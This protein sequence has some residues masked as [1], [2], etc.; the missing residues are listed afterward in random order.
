[1]AAE[2]PE[3]DIANHILQAL[4]RGSYERLRG[5]LEPVPLPAKAVIYRADETIDQVFFVESGFVSMVKSMSDGRTVE[6]G[7][8][9]KEGLVGLS[10]LHGMDRSIF[11]CIVQIPGL[12]FRVASAPL[13]REMRHDTALREVTLRYSYVTVDQ[14]A[15]T[16][17]CNRL[18]SL[19]QRCTRWLL[20]AQDAAA[21]DSF[22][23]THE[24]IA[25]MLGVQRPQVSVVLNAMHRSGL[26]RTTRGRV[27]IIDRAGLERL[28]C[29]CY[30]T[31]R[32]EISQIF[33]R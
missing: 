29:E 19:E 1:M 4:P 9:G 12:A 8:I 11:D 14:I 28:S 26:I 5:L 27:T 7:G 23:L 32:R 24:F 33:E 22:P 30:G 3:R 25:V 21:S 15:Q 6:I 2:A 17:A 31:L 13:L 18:H 16:A 20:I 10:A